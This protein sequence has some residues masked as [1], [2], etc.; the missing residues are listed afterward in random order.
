MKDRVSS[1]SGEAAPRR[2]DPGATTAPALTEMLRR[3]L[4]ELDASAVGVTRANG[5]PPRY[6][7]RNAIAARFFE[8]ICSAGLETLKDQTQ[9]KS[10]VFGTNRVKED[11]SGPVRG[12]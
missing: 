1:P 9:A 6:F 8:D 3:A 4:A 12:R 5:G 7:T 11:E 10:G 2:F